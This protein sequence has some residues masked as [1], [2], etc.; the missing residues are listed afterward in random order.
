VDA[1]IVALA[2][3]NAALKVLPVPVVKLCVAVINSPR[4]DV[5]IAC[6]FAMIF[7]YSKEAVE[8]ERTTD[9]FN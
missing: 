8:P 5:H 1:L 2:K 6:V 9:F 3:N 7:P 4:N